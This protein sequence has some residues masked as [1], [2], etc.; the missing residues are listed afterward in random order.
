MTVTG[1]RTVKV[2]RLNDTKTAA[3]RFVASPVKAKN[4]GV[5]PMKFCFRS[6]KITLLCGSI[7]VSRAV[8]MLKISKSQPEEAILQKL[9]ENRRV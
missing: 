6:A 3:L 9:E 2:R 1:V 7:S 8:Y 5:F 4:G